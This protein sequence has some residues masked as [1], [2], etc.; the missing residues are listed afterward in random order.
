MDYCKDLQLRSQI[1]WNPKRFS[2][3]FLL[4]EATKFHP[5]LTRIWFTK[6][7]KSYFRVAPYFAIYYMFSLVL[8]ESEYR[9]KWLGVNGANALTKIM[10]FILLCI[11]VQL[12][13]NGYLGIHT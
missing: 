3:D 4:R 2:I 8:R 7:V 6:L 1:L 10:G 9:M 5:A 12:V 11:G 13:I